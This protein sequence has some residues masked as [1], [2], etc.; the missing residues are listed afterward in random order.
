MDLLTYYR[1]RSKTHLSRQLIFISRIASS[2]TVPVSLCQ[3]L[4]PSFCSSICTTTGTESA[5]DDQPPNALSSWVLWPLVPTKR[6]WENVVE[7]KI[8]KYT[9]S[10][11]RYE[12]IVGG[13][14]SHRSLLPPTTNTHNHHRMGRALGRC[15]QVCRK[16]YK[17]SEFPKWIGPTTRWTH[18]VSHSS[19]SSHAPV[20]IILPQHFPLNGSSLYCR[21][22]T[23]THVLFLPLPLYPL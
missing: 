11:Y 13:S 4:C 7:R 8:W 19:S 2:T 3:C 12:L 16:H 22:R 1:Y 10:T 20:I 17:T 15:L 9:F 5:K 6:R 23:T 18:F 21:Q 14:Y